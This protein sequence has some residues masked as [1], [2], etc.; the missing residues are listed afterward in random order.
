MVKK[1]IVYSSVI[2]VAA[3]LLI[4]V[5]SFLFYYVN[6]QDQGKQ[7]LKDEYILNFYISFSDSFRYKVLKKEISI[8]TNLNKHITINLID[9]PFGDLD[10]K[11]RNGDLIP[12]PDL[13]V[14]NAPS[15]YSSDIFVVDP[16]P[17]YRRGWLLF[18]NKEVL[19]AVGIDP[20]SE[21]DELSLRLKKGEIGKDEFFQIFN[22]VSKA[23][24]LPITLGAKYKWPLSAW[25]QHLTAFE[26]GEKS[27]VELLSETPDLNS[28]YVQKALDNFRHFM[29]Q[30]WVNT[31]YR[32]IDW[33]TA[34]GSLIS[35]EACFTL[36]SENLITSLSP[37]SR[38]VIGFLPF[39]G[40][41]EGE[42]TLWSIGSIMY[43]GIPSSTLQKKEAEE[44]MQFLRSSGATGRLSM[45][46]LFPFYSE[47][48]VSSLKLIPSI[49]Y[50]TSSPIH[51]E[52]FNWFY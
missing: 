2:L 37:E 48:R 20:N 36:L 13:I 12:A 5:I 24:I 27:A 29:N 28:H 38:N 34:L 11:F 43:L 33:P 32:D 7:E 8:Y 3:I 47:E 9:I 31:S 18:Y 16:L 49:S 52:I 50:R 19:K 51:N 15:S 30:Q 25:I 40:N 14:S 45:N 44:F 42:S 17:W 10:K 6:T 26:G 21:T 39:P 22:R 1:K 23:G 41:A 46:L 35:G 4:L